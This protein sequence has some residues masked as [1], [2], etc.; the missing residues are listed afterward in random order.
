MQSVR[1]VRQEW[2]GLSATGAGRMV[3]AKKKGKKAGR[4]GAEGPFDIVAE[5]RAGPILRRSSPAFKQARGIARLYRTAKVLQRGRRI[6]EIARPLH[7][8][9]GFSISSHLP[10]LFTA[11]IADKDFWD[12]ACGFVSEERVDFAHEALAA[13]VDGDHPLW[14]PAYMRF[15][16]DLPGGRL[17]LETLRAGI[18][19]H[20]TRT[21]QLAWGG[22]SPAQQA[23][24]LAVLRASH[25]DVQ[26]Q[27]NTVLE[28]DIVR[29]VRDTDDEMADA[30]GMVTQDWTLMELGWRV[31]LL[32]VVG[33][34][35]AAGLAKRTL[36]AAFFV[37]REDWDDEPFHEYLEL[38]PAVW[39]LALSMLNLNDVWRRYFG[40]CENYK[41]R[42]IE[43][44]SVKLHKPSRTQLPR[45]LGLLSVGG[46]RFAELNREICR[47]VTVWYKS[48]ADM[49]LPERM[50]G[51][52]AAGKG[53]R[54]D[55]D[56]KVGILEG[57]GRFSYRALASK[58]GLPE[59]AL[60]KRIDRFL[61][62]H[63][64]RDS[65][66][67]ALQKPGRRESSYTLEEKALLPV[68]NAM[69]EERGQR[70]S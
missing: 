57:A 41:S 31:L 23:F 15:V 58:H 8:L 5:L 14:M 51:P 42:R 33:L 3:M 55:S 61:E 19:A 22:G 67:Q 35:D 70:Q 11:A 32:A 43:T 25:A 16:G 48:T 46:D 56:S 34:A 50:P 21:G 52:G 54:G 45:D 39:G 30:H 28:A 9:H 65:I 68:I 60:R 7:G 6:G 10:F 2:R 44:R 13:Y 40:E 63:P 37:L 17:F 49:S 27:V 59:P 66:K 53:E 1:S 62:N 26:H 12:R 69:K 20:V 18:V 36:D 38:S 47:E 64:K 24:I 29:V 4:K